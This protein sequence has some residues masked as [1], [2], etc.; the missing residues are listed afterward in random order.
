MAVYL[1]IRA[2]SRSQGVRIGNQRITTDTTAYVD[3][4]DGKTRRELQNH[5]AL[6]S[7]IVVGP[8]SSSN[9]DVV[10]DSGYVVSEGTTNT[11]LTVG[12]TAGEL[13]NRATGVSVAYAG[14]ADSGATL[15]AADG[16]NPRVDLV[17]ADN[18]SGAVS[19]VDGTATA[20]A[21]LTN[22]TGAPAVPA[23]K[24]KLAYTLLA[25]GATAITNA[26]I[27]DARPR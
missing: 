7:V 4:S 12:V 3:I 2:L 24:T 25:A 19:K 15:A 23:G 18:T 5:S 11:N 27:Q 6:G 1:P 21:N 22:K 26:N 13:R 14:S 10:V 8:L 16:T 17:V 20:G 9:S